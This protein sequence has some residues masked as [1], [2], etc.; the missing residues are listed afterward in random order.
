MRV[1]IARHGP[2]RVPLSIIFDNSTVLV[3]L[4]HFFMCDRNL[5]DGEN[6]RWEDVPVVHLL[7][8]PASSPSGA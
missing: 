2:G 3:N 7:R 5:V 8:S 4:N 6:R 1:K